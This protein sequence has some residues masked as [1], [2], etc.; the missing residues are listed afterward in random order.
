MGRWRRG[1][2]GHEI[3]QVD[4]IVMKYTTMW[5]CF[6]QTLTNAGWR[7]TGAVRIAIIQQAATHAAAM[8]GILSIAMDLHVMVCCSRVRD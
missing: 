2:G 6:V 1:E 3:C 7:S 8:L 4:I 5:F